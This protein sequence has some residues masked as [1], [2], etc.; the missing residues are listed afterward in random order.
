MLV[1]TIEVDHSYVFV[2]YCSVVVIV[3][4]DRIVLLDASSLEQRTVIKSN[5][6]AS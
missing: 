6:L 4:Q 3:L 1:F 2:L 5:F